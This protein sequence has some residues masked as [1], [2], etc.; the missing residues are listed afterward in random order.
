MSNKFW[1]EL[2]DLLD[3]RVIVYFRNTS[4]EGKLV[5]VDSTQVLV[6]GKDKMYHY[7]SLEEFEGYERKLW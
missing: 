6:V 2:K 1:E 4:C 7:I 3:K 5:Q